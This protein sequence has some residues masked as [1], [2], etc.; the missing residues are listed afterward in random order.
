MEEPNDKVLSRFEHYA[1]FMELQQEM[2]SVD[3]RSHPTSEERLRISLASQRLSI[4]LA[5]YQEQPYLLDPF[6]ETLVTPIVEKLKSHAVDAVSNQMGLGP[7]E[8]IAQL[9]QLLLN[10]IKFRG[11]KTI[12]RFFPHEISDLSVALDYIGVVEQ[13]HHLNYLWPLH[14]AVL[15]WV[16]LICMIPFDLSQFDEDGHAGRTAAAIETAGRRNLV[17]SGL[18]R[19][20]AAVLLARFYVRKDTRARLSEFLHWSLSTIEED[21]GIFEALGLMQT[22]YEVVKTCPQDTLKLHIPTIFQITR[23]VERN[24]VLMA[25]TVVRKLRMKLLSRTALRLLP[26]RAR[27]KQP[28]GRVLSSDHGNDSQDDADD[29]HDVPEEIETSL[30]D[31]FQALEDRDTIVRWSAAKG[32][33]RVCERLSPEFTSQVV[34]TVMGL[35]SIHSLGVASLYD[36]PAVAESTWHGACL[37]CAELTRRGLIGVEKLPDL[38]GWVSKALYFDIRKGAHSIGSSVRDAAAYILWSLARTYSTAQIQPFAGDLAARLVTISVYDREVHVRRAVSAAFQEF[39]GRTG[40]FPH[41]I[42]VLGKTDF[43][44]IGV[45][46]NAFLIAAPQVAEHMEYQPFLLDHLVTVTLRHWDPS[47]RELAAQSLRKICELDLVNLG[48]KYAYRARELL[49]MPDTNDIHGAL[50]ALTELAYAF[51]ASPLSGELEEQRREIFSFL[52]DVPF[53]V[54]SSPRHAMVTTAACHLIASSISLDQIL[55]DTKHDMPRMEETDPSKKSQRQLP[56]GPVWRR[57]VDLGLKHRDSSVQKAAATA[58]AVVSRLTDCVLLVDTLIRDFRSG[59]PSHQE[60]LAHVL[61]ELDYTAHHHGLPEVVRCLL[62]SVDSGSSLR[63]ANVEARRNCFSSMSNI[64]T[65]LAPVLHDHLN[66]AQVRAMYDSLISG[67]E[68]YTIDERGDVG[69]WIR[70]ACIRGLAV[71]SLTLFSR[72]AFLPN[73]PDY[74]PSDKYHAAIAGTLKQGVERL[75]NVRQEAGE[76]FLRLLTSPLPSTPDAEQ[77]CIRGQS[78]LQSLFLSEPIPVGWQDSL[79]LFPKAVRLLEIPEYRSHIFLGLLMS[80]GSKTHSTQLPVTN[81]L[82]AFVRSLPVSSPDGAAYDMVAFVEFAVDQAKSQLGLNSKVIPVLQLFNLLL[83]ADALQNLAEDEAGIKAL[84]TLLS[85]ASRGV[86]KLKSVQRIQECMKVVV[87]L[88]SVPQLHDSCV[89]RL[90]DFLSHHFPT[91]RA[92]TAEYLYLVLQSRDIGRDT[93]DCE[94]VLLETEWLTNNAEAAT[95]EIVQMLL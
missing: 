75:D 76:Q 87:N 20:S 95:R 36:M 64:M 14:Y 28:K 54:L 45:R 4:I 92:A 29:E 69:S 71:F 5:G 39:V 65:T 85:V 78:L 80:T 42:D 61:G 2:L 63:M 3:L 40:V 57:I 51:S 22:T 55:L 59:S 23:S 21:K 27:V 49:K 94:E 38:V 50:L 17:K 70:I 32:V 56:K 44:A 90:S 41:G 16:S 93:D 89:P 24:S 79:W 30:Q 62:E 9:S 72:S 83:E 1:E 67:L 7:K 11:Y 66:K 6:L 15:L 34:D 48:R 86:S 77:W 60:S 37:A 19:E 74:L 12:T 68:D 10:Y 47:M 13:D 81:S 53:D 18:N 26:A 25:N 58:L 31:I 43:F 88:L 35:F 84:Q 82:I 8:N 33:A 73:F 46:K 91:V 52:A